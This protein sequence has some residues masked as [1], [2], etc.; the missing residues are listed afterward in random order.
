MIK[1]FLIMGVC[2][3]VFSGCS[4]LEPVEDHEQIEVSLA[5]CWDGDTAHFYLDHTDVKTRFLA[6][7]APE[8]NTAAGDESARYVCEVLSQATRIEFEFDE[9]SDRED[10]FGRTLAW[11]WVDGQLLQL[12]LIEK[13]YARLAYVYGDYKYVDLLKE[14]RNK[15]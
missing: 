12:D 7:D 9:N 10:K 4:I 11:I 2:F 3:L 15:R 6:I 14:A 8:L 5:S 1:R 13:G